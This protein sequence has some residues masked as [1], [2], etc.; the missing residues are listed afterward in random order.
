MFAIVQPYQYTMLILVIFCLF[1]TM[2]FFGIIGITIRN[3]FQNIFIFLFYKN[4]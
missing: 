4:N 3:R 2:K 1:A